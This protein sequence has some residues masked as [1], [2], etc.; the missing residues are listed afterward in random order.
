L[1]LSELKL[2]LLWGGVA[3]QALYFSEMLPHHHVI[4]NLI[5]GF[6]LNNIVRGGWMV[7]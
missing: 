6:E 2:L 3:N 4:A 1:L 7:W 5:D